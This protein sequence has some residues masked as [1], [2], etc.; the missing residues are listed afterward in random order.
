MKFTISL[1]LLGSLLAPAA[2]NLQNVKLC[3]DDLNPTGR[4]QV[5]IECKGTSADFGL[6]D[7]GDF[8]D[9]FDKSKAA[10]FTTT[11]GDIQVDIKYKIMNAMSD[12]KSDNKMW[13]EWGFAGQGPNTRNEGS[14]GSNDFLNLLPPSN[15]DGLL[16]PSNND[17]DYSVPTVYGP[18]RSTVH[19]QRVT[20]N[21]C[22]IDGSHQFYMKMRLKPFR[23]K[24]DNQSTETRNGDYTL[25]TT[26]T[27]GTNDFIPFVMA[28]E[29]IP[30]APATSPTSKSPEDKSP[31]NQGK[32]TGKATRNTGKGNGR[33]TRSRRTKRASTIGA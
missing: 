8:F 19:K 2:A 22:S 23:F 16:P 10:Q 31:T 33:Y 11:C 12:K 25:F 7:E 32:A 20:V 1:I 13:Y 3:E 4:T 17:G 26:H 29:G 5:R 18:Q 14:S 27:C 28:N 9:C 24:D 15:D 21:P 30:D 6:S